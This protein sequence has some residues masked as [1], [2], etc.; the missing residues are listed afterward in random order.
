M[1]IQAFEG[2]KAIPKESYLICP[3]FYD[4]IILTSFK[5]RTFWAHF[6]MIMETL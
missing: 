2:V 4:D 3:E 6:K 1:V 5:R